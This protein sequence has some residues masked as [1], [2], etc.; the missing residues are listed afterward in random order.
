MDKQ[1]L[2]RAAYYMFSSKRWSWSEYVLF[3]KK[4]GMRLV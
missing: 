2:Q 1:A 4:N 3:C